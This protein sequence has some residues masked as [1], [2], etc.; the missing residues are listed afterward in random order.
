MATITAIAGLTAG[1]IESAADS[2]PAQEK[3]AGAMSGGLS[4]RAV[5]GR[6]AGQSSSGGL[7]PKRMRSA[8]IEAKAT[9]VRLSV[10]AVSPSP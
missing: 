1:A 4:M 3:A 7:I 9:M 10:Q 5:A 8:L 2:Q 6:G